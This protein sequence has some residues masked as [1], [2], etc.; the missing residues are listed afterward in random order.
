MAYVN[1]PANLQDM[2][3]ALK[4]R[5][6]KLE[7]GPNSAA[8][9][10]GT[11]LALATSSAADAATALAKANTAVQTSASTI[12][13]SSNQLTAINTT[14][15]SVYTASSGARVVMNSA[16][17]AGYNSGGS[18]T[19][20]ISSSDG[21]VA[22][23]GSLITGGTISGATVTAY[24]GAI[25]GWALSSTRLSANSGLTYLDSSSG[26]FATIGTINAAGF[27]TVSG[28][29]STGGTMSCNTLNVLGTSALS[30]VNSSGVVTNNSS[31]YL[32][33][34]AIASTTTSSANL[35]IN[36]SSG[37]LARYSSS[38]E[39][40]KENIVDISTIPTLDPEALLKIPVRS[41]TYKAGYL[42]EDDARLNAP[43]PGFIAEE[44]LAVYPIAVD[45]ENGKPETWNPKYIIPGMLAL[46]QKQEA[47]ITAL[48]G[49]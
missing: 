27:A 9:D 26:N 14:G 13:N 2:F 36:S 7:T 8:T 23:T 47:R 12:V 33:G 34:T 30:T 5:I 35:F 6:A 21:S 18:P 1:L 38:S 20:A 44:V 37:F 31:T 16:G 25:G 49:K 22:I 42:A 4:D 10:A 3:N 28:T 19:F 29:I 43:V 17:L 15:I 40:Y 24:A 48:E 46:I 39:R 41:F 11:A 32:Y 45:E